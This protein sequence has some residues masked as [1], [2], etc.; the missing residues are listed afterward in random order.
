[1][2]DSLLRDALQL[3]QSGRL[4][5]AERLYGEVVKENPGHCEA[6]YLLGIA[7]AP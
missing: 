3:H 6:L 2:S 7:G 4:Q 5:D 1:M